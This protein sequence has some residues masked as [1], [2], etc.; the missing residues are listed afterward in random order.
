MVRGGRGIRAAESLCCG[1]VRGCGVLSM[2]ME[3]LV[4]VAG[5]M[6]V[7]EKCERNKQ[8]DSSMTAAPLS[9]LLSF[10]LCLSH[11]SHH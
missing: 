11:L 2:F 3:S 8:L 4:W 5:K 10:S 7:L 9:L 1:L 6:S